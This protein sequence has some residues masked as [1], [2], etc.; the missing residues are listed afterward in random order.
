VRGVSQA[1]LRTLVAVAL[2]VVVFPA[3][4]AARTTPRPDLDV[5]AYPVQGRNYVFNGDRPDSFSTF[6]F[7]V[8]NW[9][10]GRAGPVLARLLLVHSR[11]GLT[12]RLGGAAVP[13]LP[14]RRRMTRTASTPTANF[15]AGAYR[16][17][18]CVDSR[19]QVAESNELNNCATFPSRYYVLN[20]LYRGKISGTVPL[21]ANGDAMERWQMTDAVYRFDH[22]LGGGSFS[23]RLTGTVRF[24]DSGSS[25]GCN[26]TGSAVDG[27]PVGTLILAYEANQYTV[28]GQTSTSYPLFN[29][30]LQPPGYEPGPRMP[31]FLA[32][33]APGSLHVL[34]FG[35]VLADAVRIDDVSYT[36]SLAG[37]PR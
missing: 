19:Q 35:N 32:S 4:A 17:R 20:K 6:K 22:P 10:R 9:G 8:V 33:A 26:Y 16:V 31:T 30:C 18:V 24:T 2:V 3:A 15:K 27:N 12:Y 7:M 11:T 14:A 1:R 28:S 23:Y 5:L 29:D 21:A 25:N 37:A 34:P 36:W 13:A